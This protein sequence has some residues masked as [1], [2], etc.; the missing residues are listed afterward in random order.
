MRQIAVRQNAHIAAISGGDSRRVVSAIDSEILSVCIAVNVAIF[1]TTA[2][3]VRLV[4]RA[5]EACAVAT[6]SVV[7][8]AVCRYSILGVMRCGV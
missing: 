3:A 8:R 2:Q 7:H 5:F 6:G 1:A 4:W